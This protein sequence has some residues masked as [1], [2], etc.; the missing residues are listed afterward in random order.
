MPRLNSIISIFFVLWHLSVSEVITHSFRWNAI[1]RLFALLAREGKSHAWKNMWRNFR[2]AKKVSIVRFRRV[3]V[4]RNEFDG[5]K[6]INIQWDSVCIA[7]KPVYTLSICQTL[8]THTRRTCGMWNTT[9][10]ITI[11]FTA[12]RM[13]KLRFDKIETIECLTSKNVIVF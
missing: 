12:C 7:I 5:K 4:L 9:E 3:C 11:T 1:S 8:M 10:I 6:R 2:A 13:N